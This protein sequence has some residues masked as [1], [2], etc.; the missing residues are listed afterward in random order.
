MYFTRRPMKVHDITRHVRKV[1]MH[2]L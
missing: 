2:H 1:K